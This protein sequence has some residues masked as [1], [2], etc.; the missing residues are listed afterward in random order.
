M[1]TAIDHPT[2]PVSVHD[3]IDRTEALLPAIAERALQTERERRLPEATIH[4]IKAAG[5]NRV[6][7]PVRWGGYGLDFD[8][9]FEV[10]WRLSSACG[11][12]GWVYSQAAV[13]NWEMSFAPHEAQAEF[14]AKPDPLSCSA[15]NPGGAKVESV[16]GGWMLSGRW[17][18]SSGVFHADWALLGTKVDEIPGPVLLMVP[19]SD[20]RIEDTWH[21]SGLRGTGSNDVVIDAPVFIPSHRYIWPGDPANPAAKSSDN[22]SYRVPMPSIAPWG[23]VVPVIGMAQGALDAY[24]VA[25]FTRKTAFGGKAMAPM[26]GPQ[27]RIAEA[28]A[29]LDS[30]RA[31]ARRDIEEAIGLGRQGDTLTNADR[32]RFRRDHAHVVD[33]CFSATML[34]ARAAGASSLFETNPIQR[35]VRDVHAGSMQVATNWDE[36]AEAYGR[37]RM[38]LEPNSTMW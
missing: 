35:F 27:L 31:L 30:A 21:V 33:T 19:K 38:G 3:L 15:F 11:S 7:Q 26:I 13:Q 14:Y 4:D 24:E 2:P 6:M 36:Q 32:T 8:A 18:F 34:I 20:F 29:M 12:T 25:N 23:V 1:K 28:S 22:G 9:Y 17:R 5:L 16:A 10:C 37:V